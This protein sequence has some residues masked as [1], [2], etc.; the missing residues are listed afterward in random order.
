VATHNEDGDTFLFGAFSIADAM[1]LPVLSRFQSY[2]IE[3]PPIVQQY[4]KLMLNLPSYKQWL[5]SA[6]AEVEVIADS[7]L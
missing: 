3:V 1:Y 5:Q 7:E 4:M 6:V 2:Q